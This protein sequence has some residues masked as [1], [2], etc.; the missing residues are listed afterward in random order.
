MSIIVHRCNHLTAVLKTE[1]FLLLLDSR[2]MYLVFLL[3]GVVES[4]PK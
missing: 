2:D 1:A 3:F 4:T